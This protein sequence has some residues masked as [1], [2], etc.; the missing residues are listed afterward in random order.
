MAFAGRALIKAG[1]LA[2]IAHF[3]HEMPLKSLVFRG[4]CLP[5]S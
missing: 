1:L 3:D 4:L 2:K 5:M